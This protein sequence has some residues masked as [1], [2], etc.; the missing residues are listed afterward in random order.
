MG[1]RADSRIE[2]FV[3]TVRGEYRITE[4]IFFGSRARGDYLAD[5]D[6]HIVLVSPDFE[7]VF[8]SQRTQETPD[9]HRQRSCQGRHRPVSHFREAGS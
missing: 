1:Q 9:R 6:Y 5:S 4:A 2:D 7:G 3:A 8:F